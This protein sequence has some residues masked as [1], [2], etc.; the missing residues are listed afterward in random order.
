MKP[1]FAGSPLLQTYQVG[2]CHREEARASVQ[3]GFLSVFNDVSPFFKHI[4]WADVIARKL[5]RPFK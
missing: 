3:V 1:V 4:K 2:R 5:E